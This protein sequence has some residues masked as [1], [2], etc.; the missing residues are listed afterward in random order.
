MNGKKP[1]TQEEFE[2]KFWEKVS[3]KSPYE[4]WPWVASRRKDGYGKYK[5][6]GKNHLAHRCSFELE[7]GAVLPSR[8]LVC[9]SCDN[10]WC[11]NP[12]HFF[13]GENDANLKDAAMKGLCNRGEDRWNAKLTEKDVF[14]IRSKYKYR[15]YSQEKISKEFGVSRKAVAMVVTGKSWKHVPVP[16]LEIV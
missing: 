12:N 8:V 6:S 11:C 1:Y 4:C 3:I 10:R 2:R 5:R 14:Q 15:T 9:H 13:L 16:T 7:Y